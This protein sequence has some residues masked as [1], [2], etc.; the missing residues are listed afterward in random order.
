MRRP[1]SIAINVCGLAYS[2]RLSSYF[3]SFDGG[4]SAAAIVA[5]KTKGSPKIMRLEFLV[6]HVEIIAEMGV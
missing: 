3:P 2:A 4:A 6:I 1:P 5:P